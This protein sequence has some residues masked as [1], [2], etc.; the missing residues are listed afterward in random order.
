L[1]SSN[2]DAWSK[3][4]SMGKELNPGHAL[5]AAAAGAAGMALSSDDEELDDLG[6]ELE[7]ALSETV[8]EEV[9]Q[10]S[11]D[12]DEIDSMDLSGLDNLD[13]MDSESL[14][15]D[16]SLDSEFLDKMESGTVE[17]VEESL[18]ID[19]GDL[20]VESEMQSGAAALEEA[21]SE[22]KE[23]TGFEDSETLDNIDL[24]SIE[25]ELESL[26]ED[27][28]SEIAEPLELPEADSHEISMD[29][30][31]TDEVTTKLDLA[32]AYIDMGDNEGA[33]SILE[34]VVS[35]GSEQQQEEAKQ[36]MNN[37]GA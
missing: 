24:E 23:A 33:K 13:E 19:L 32:R 36:L 2:P 5:F 22:L 8:E 34:E 29:L 14:E 6:L 11:L 4:V 37:I 18:D 16:I 7:S 27:L 25:Q 3:I 9:P 35:E 26:S 10:E 30:D 21:E 15:A 17:D 20:D 28:D 31:S 12:S 1:E